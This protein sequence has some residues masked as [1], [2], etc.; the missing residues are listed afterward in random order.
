MRGI[1][2]FLYRP[3]ASGPWSG[4]FSRLDFA[5]LADLLAPERLQG[6]FFLS[7]NDLPVV[8]ELFAA[9]HI[10]QV[11]TTYQA[12]TRHGRAK[13]VHELLI[14]NYELPVLREKPAQTQ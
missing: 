2:G 9:F 1:T 8:R 13:P 6:K 7:L 12:G 14:A 3:L 4:I 11:S 10:L 5:E